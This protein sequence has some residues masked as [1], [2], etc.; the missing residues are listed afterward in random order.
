M[1]Q[2]SSTTVQS[3]AAGDVV[4]V[5]FPYSDKLSEKRRPALV[6]STAALHQLGLIW[7]VMITSAALE[8]HGD[9]AVENWQD[10]GLPVASTIR[11]AK[12]AC[13]E[14]ARIVRRA[15]AVSQDVFN[16]VATHLREFI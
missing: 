2:I 3:F 12:I 10:A 14:P 13:L 9:V 6:V 7:V 1:G 5:P 8:V 15:G 16:K 4:V 11:T